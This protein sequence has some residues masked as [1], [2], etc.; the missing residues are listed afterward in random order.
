M[1]AIAAS[2]ALLLGVVGIY[3]V[4][5][6]DPLTYAAVPVILVSATVLAIYL[7]ARQI[8]AVDSVEALRSE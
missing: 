3:G 8:V 4:L 7:P 5:S 6:L 2:M 1:L